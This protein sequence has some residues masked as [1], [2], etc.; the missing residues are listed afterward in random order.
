ETAKRGRLEIAP[1]RLEL[2]GPQDRQRML[3]T[4]VFADGSRRD[5][6]REAVV[7]ATEAR[8]ANVV[9]GECYPAAH[10]ETEITANFNGRSATIPV[11]VGS[12]TGGAPSFVNDVLPL[13]T[14]LGCNRGACHG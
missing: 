8:V 3:V 6:S 14:R 2:S 4:A 7:T 9:G 12:G 5:V 10:G 1:G 13:V 11:T